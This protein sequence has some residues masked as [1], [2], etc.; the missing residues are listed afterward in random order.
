[1]PDNRIIQHEKLQT[2]ANQLKKNSIRPNLSQDELIRWQTPELKSGAASVIPSDKPHLDAFLTKEKDIVEKFQPANV[3]IPLWLKA[4]IETK[5]S[6]PD[7]L[8][9]L[10]DRVKKA[11]SKDAL[12]LMQMVLNDIGRK[13]DGD[14]HFNQLIQKQNIP[15]FI[16]LT[17]PLK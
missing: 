11:P 1:M 7:V 15:E 17:Q 4:K 2:V 3:E 13:P 12:V 14:M 8:N 5:A 16:N 9:F 6:P 10:I